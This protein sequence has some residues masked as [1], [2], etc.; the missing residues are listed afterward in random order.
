MRKTVLITGCSTGIG[1]ATA[2]KFQSLGWNV[3][4]TMRTP[5]QDNTLHLL[6]RTICPKLDVTDLGSMQT[7]LE[8]TLNHFGTID[9][10]VNNTGYGLTGPFEGLREEQIYRQFETNVFGL[11]RLTQVLLPLFRVNQKGLIINVSS[12]GGRIIFPFYSVYHATKWAVEGFTESL[13]FEVEPLG[14]RVK[15]IEP[16]AVKT[17]FYERSNDNSLK[18]SPEEYRKYTD[19]AFHNMNQAGRDGIDAQDVANVIYQA[20]T[21]NSKKLRYPVGQ[22]AKLFLFLRRFATDSFFASLVKAV[23]FKKIRN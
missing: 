8:E 16:G 21:D 14:I 23:V 3:A 2:L 4:A 9:V 5:E 18:L 15:L 22:K 19:I 13:R 7:A 12:M 11:M 20:A 10:L 1:H 17:D 6:E